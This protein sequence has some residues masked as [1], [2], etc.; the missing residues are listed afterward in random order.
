MQVKG[1]D[2]AISQLV[3]DIAE[4]SSRKGSTLN[5]EGRYAKR[6]A[7]IKMMHR[8][9]YYL[10]AGRDEVARLPDLVALPIEE[11]PKAK[12]KKR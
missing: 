12:G 2:G 1:L 11:A 8:A 6:T 9:L 10:E 3:E 4:A 7:A 5:A